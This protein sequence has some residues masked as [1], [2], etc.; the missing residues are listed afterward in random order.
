MVSSV[1]Y[2]N[3][4]TLFLTLTEFPFSATVIFYCLLPPPKSQS[5][6]ASE[7]YSLKR[8][9]LNIEPRICPSGTFWCLDW[10]LLADS[11]PK[12]CHQ[13]ANH[14]FNA[15]VL[16]WL[17]RCIPSIHPPSKYSLWKPEQTSSFGVMTWVKT[18]TGSTRKHLS[19]FATP[20]PGTQPPLWQFWREGTSSG[21]QGE[22]HWSA[23][24]SQPFAHRAFHLQPVCVPSQFSTG[25]LPCP[26]TFLFLFAFGWEPVLFPVFL[27]HLWFTA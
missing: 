18:D 12:C 4:K 27:H 14:T 7:F 13:A 11:V 24:I 26:C 20:V 6:A 2:T 25:V 10:R 1:H 3:L 8:K 17:L 19:L 16:L 15:P 5:Y 9:T 22:W 23:Y 21:G